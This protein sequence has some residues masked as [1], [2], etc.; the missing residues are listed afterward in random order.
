MFCS[1]KDKEGTQ[2]LFCTRSTRHCR[3]LKEIFTLMLLFHLMLI[4]YIF[5]TSFTQK[6]AF[7]AILILRNTFTLLVLCRAQNL[8]YVLRWYRAHC[9]FNV[10]SQL[11][12]SIYINAS[13]CHF[14]STMHIAVYF[15][16]QNYW[17]QQHSD[18]FVFP[19]CLC[20]V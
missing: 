1:Y 10:H 13:F 8:Q 20:L 9:N 11:S 14:P 4:K 17:M 18:N 16:T 19:K 7:A 15:I 2:V 6:N 12:L 5:F 3:R